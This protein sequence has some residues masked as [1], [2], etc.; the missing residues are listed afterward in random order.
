MM[1]RPLPDQSPQTEVVKPPAGPGAPGP[2]PAR[3]SWPWAIA[4]L[5]LG[6]IAVVALYWE[7]AWSMVTTWR[8]SP[9]FSHGFLIVP[10]SAYLVW[11]Q[12]SR[13]ARVCPRSS[14]L[15]LGAAALGALAWLIGETAGVVLVQQA[16]FVFVLQSLFLAALGPK[17]TRLIAFP[18]LYLY[19]AVP[20]GTFLIAPLQDLTAIFVVRFLQLVGIPV[21]LDGI[22]IYIPSGSFEVAEACAGVRFLIASVALGAI[23]AHEF[24]RQLWRRMLFMALSIGVPIVANG[25]RATG[26]V[27]LAHYSNY[28]IAVGADHLTYG[29]IFLSFVLFCL[30]GLGFLFREAYRAPDLEPDAEPAQTSS[31]A[32]APQSHPASAIGVALIAAGSW[33]YADHVDSR[34]P[35]GP[36]VFAPPTLETWEP[37]APAHTDWKPSFPNSSQEYLLG[38]QDGEAHVDL[39]VAYFAQQHQGAE[40]VNWNNS[41]TGQ[42]PW[43]RAGRGGGETAVGPETLDFRYERIIDGPRG[44]MVWYWYWVDGRLTASPYVAKLLEVKAKLLGGEQAAAVIAVAADYSGN[45]STSRPAFERFLTQAWPIDRVFGRPRG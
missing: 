29:F 7:T 13:L 23:F 21:Y 18:L 15:G 30:L 26:L 5:A 24:Y 10:I 12:R 14:M 43:Q 38:F 40:V 27:F 16:A 22:F 3:T 4:A 11:Q 25:F 33:A 31:F 36:L 20:F 39:Y 2:K 41:L 28:E 44:R 19:F 9:A 35:G 17:A 8:D 42:N 6:S 34:T 37:A 1:A 32:V 45:P